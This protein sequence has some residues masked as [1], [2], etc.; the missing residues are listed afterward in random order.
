M[1]RRHRSYSTQLALICATCMLFVC[2]TSTKQ[3]DESKHTDT[4]KKT[5]TTDR[6]ID[7][8]F[9][10]TDATDLI[11]RL[12][13]SPSVLVTTPDSLGYVT[14]K[15][16]IHNDG[17]DTLVMSDVKGSCGCAGVSVQ[18]NRIARLDSGM[19]YL[20]INTKSFTEPSNNVDFTVKSNA[21][22]SPAVFRV[23]INVPKK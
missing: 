5:D 20:Q 9:K 18:R 7:G 8:T 21:E 13:F 3:T 1:P 16:Y 11:P 15:V 23:I 14:S 17:G 19:I 22:N 4:L 6:R 10:K 12:R 2:C